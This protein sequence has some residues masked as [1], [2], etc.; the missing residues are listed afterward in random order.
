[1]RRTA[2]TLVRLKISIRFISSS[3][4][5]VLLLSSS[6]ALLINVTF[7][8]GLANSAVQMASSYV[9][10]RISSPCLTS[11]F[12]LYVF[13]LSLDRLLHLPHYPGWYALLR[14]S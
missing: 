13:N 1:M 10:G 4:E 6:H 5:G 7:L 2:A 11:D 9:S 14:G 8:T 12:L 3:S